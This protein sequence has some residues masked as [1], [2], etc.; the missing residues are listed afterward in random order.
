MVGS[1]YRLIIFG[2]VLL[3]APVVGAVVLTWWLGAYALVFGVPCSS[4]LSS[5][6]PAQK[7]RKAPAGTAKKA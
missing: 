6:T 2:V 7:G 4:L 1:A 5:S 3:I